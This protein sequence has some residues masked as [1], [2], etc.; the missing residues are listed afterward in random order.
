[1][2]AEVASK[3]VGGVTTFLAK[4]KNRL[5]ASDFSFVIAGHQGIE[6]CIDAFGERL[7]PRS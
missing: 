3:D 6:P 5:V 7:D 2:G 4:S 1:M